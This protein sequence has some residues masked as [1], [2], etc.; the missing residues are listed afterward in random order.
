MR[1]RVMVIGGAND[2]GCIVI[3]VEVVVAFVWRISAGGDVL[4]DHATFFD[5]ML[6]DELEQRSRKFGRQV[7]R[8][9]RIPG[10]I[11]YDN[12]ILR[13]VVGEPCACGK[14]VL[15]ADGVDL[16]PVDRAIEERVGR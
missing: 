7:V 4:G 15:Y 12:D 10:S 3:D 1:H 16:G 5:A 14:A 11:A 8:A 13:R 2:E 6:S 9:E